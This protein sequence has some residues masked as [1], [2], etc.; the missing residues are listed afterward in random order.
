MYILKRKESMETKFLRYLVAAFIAVSLVAIFIT[1]SLVIIFIRQ[2]SFTKYN[3][4]P[5][6][7]CDKY[8]QETYY[9]EFEGK[10]VDFYMKNG[11]YTW[12]LRYTDEMGR[13]F[14][15]YYVHPKEVSVGGIYLFFAN[16]VCRISDH[17]WIPILEEKY[18]EKFQIKQYENL[19]L[20]LI[21]YSFTIEEEGDIEGIADII[22]TT[23]IYTKENVKK[24]SPDI[25]G[26]DVSYKSIQTH[27]FTLIIDEEVQ[28]LLNKGRNEVFNYIYNGI[29]DGY[30]EAVE[31]V[32]RDM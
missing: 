25:I 17:Y 29:Y 14:D 24:M 13:E 4:H 11:F 1:V 32:V 18:E 12:K 30:R 7:E 31:N 27:V 20:S 21:K 22:T 2:W 16:E 3:I 26:Y 9:G 15:E 28:N 23:L 10:V 6:K 19:D 5:L 8:L